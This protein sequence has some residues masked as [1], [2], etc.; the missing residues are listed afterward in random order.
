MIE[1]NVGPVSESEENLK[2][3]GPYDMIFIDHI[4]TLYLSD[5]KIL[6]EY[7]VVKS[8][9]LVVGDNIIRP[10]CPDYLAYMKA[11]PNYSSILY[12]SYI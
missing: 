2:K 6:E 4:K 1:Y 7:G 3:N 11:N 9:T 5:F 12:H 8:G 10:G